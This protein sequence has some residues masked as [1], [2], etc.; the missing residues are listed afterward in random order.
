MTSIDIR[1]SVL[2]GA[3]GQRVCW[4]SL[5][6]SADALAIAHAH[7]R[8]PDRQW[9]VVCASPAEADRMAARLAFYHREPA[10]VRLFPDAETL[11]YDSFSPHPDLV[12][13]RIRRLAELARGER[14]LIVVSAATLLARLPPAAWVARSLSLTP[15][16]QLDGVALRRQLETAGYTHVSQVMEHGDYAVRGSLIDLFPM[17]EHTPVR[18]DLFDDEIDSLKVFDPETQRSTDSLERLEI[19]PAREFPLDEEG[20]RGFRRRFRERFEGDPARTLIY[21]EVSAGNAPG[22]IEYYLPLFFD[23]T[24]SLLDYLP[25]DSLLC[26]PEGLASLLD[27][28]WQQACERHEQMAVDP[29]RPLLRPDEALCPPAPLLE[30]LTSRHRCIELSRTELADADGRQ[31]VNYA[32]ALPPPVAFDA[33]AEAPA[34]K[35]ISFLDDFGGRVLLVAESAG[36]REM[37]LDVLRSRGRS[38]VACEH[39]QGFL[40]RSPALGICVAPLDSGLV[41]PEAGLAVIAEEQLFGERARTAGRER[42]RAERDPA[43]LIRDLRDLRPGTPVVHQDHG[44][45]RFLGLVTLDV[46]SVTQEFLAL[47]YARED[48]LYVPVQ[49]LELISRYTGGPPESAPLHRLGGEQ[50]AKARRKAAEKIRDVAAELLD[51]HARR[52]AR[53]GHAFRLDEADYRAFAAA[54]PFEETED[55]LTAIDQ[56]LGDMRAPQ[57]MDRVVCGDVGFGKTEVALRASFMAVQGGRQVAVLVPTTLLA[58]QHYQ[59]FIDRFA[60]WPVRIELLSRFRTG[61]QANKVLAD[62]AAGQVDIVVGTHKLLSEGVKF[63]RLGLVIVDEEH[64]FGVRHKEALKRLRSEVDL[65]TLTATPI[66]RTLNMALGGLREL[67]LI[68][69]PPSDRLGVKTFVTQWSPAVIRE[70]CLREIKRGGQVYFVH[71]TIETMEKVAGEIEELVPEANLRIAHGQMRERDLEQI[72]LDFYHRRFNVL[73]C[74][75]IIESGIDVPTANTILINRADRFGLAQLHQ[76]RGRVGRSHHR[77][78]AYLLAPPTPALTPD[79]VKRLEAIEALEDLG[80]GFALASHDLEIRGAGELLGDEQSGQIHEIGFTMYMD[81]LERAV[82]DL[83]AGREPALEQPLFHGTEVDLGVAALLPEDYLPDVHQRLVLYK[84]ISACA[85][86]DALDELQVEMIDRFGLLPPPAKHLVQV[87]RL[88]LRAS[89]LGI[90]K[91]EMSAEGGRLKFHGDT[92]V[93]PLVL[94]GLVQREPSVYTLDGGA[95]LRVR[96]RLPEVEARYALASDLLQT[97]GSTPG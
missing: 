80:A 37:I 18:I 30:T 1:Q 77:A 78:Y 33:R 72:M 83:K 6:G 16:Q 85:D 59:T 48:K 22:G 28:Q 3:A 46:G 89:R 14:S 32:T 57:P 53:Q 93:D 31:R 35:L 63:K 34:T 43:T 76:L 69:T 86:D 39:W 42:R 70:A 91:L 71:N 5:H 45:G 49:S 9:V 61:K 97:L 8:D 82:A 96:T 13:E 73:L 12:S 50:W 56:V 36:R 21:R 79:A 65:L 84:R 40:E 2:P 52:A 68:T 44:V 74:T 26:L 41:L 67:S 15:G 64:R 23:Q 92:P 24:A 95:L 4:G 11:P 60:D 54:F 87:T 88:K 81:L 10:A 38:P 75:T 19:L 51:V 66:P 7:R 47:E 58:Q 27:A 25:D 90:Q 94:V 29:E 55:Q 20:I 62:L 17:G